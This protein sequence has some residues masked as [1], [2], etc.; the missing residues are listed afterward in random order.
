MNERAA[1]ILS[2]D[3]SGVG[4]VS[5]S[6]ALPLLTA[7]DL[8][9]CALPTA[10]LSSHTGG[11][12]ANTALDL[13]AEMPKVLTHWQTLG[14]DWQAVVLGYLGRSAMAVWQAWLPQ[15]GSVPLRL[16]DPVMGDHGKLYRG[17]GAAEVVGMRRLVT[18]ATLITPNVT[19]AQA[20]LGQPLTAAAQTPAAAAALAQAVATRFG[21]DVVLTGVSLVDGAIGVFGQTA[22][23]AWAQRAP[24]T[25]GDY[26]GTGDLFTALLAGAIVRGW[27]I[28]DA[29]ALAAEFIRRA[30]AYTR[31]VTADPRFGVAYAPILP[32]LITQ[33][34]TTKEA[35]HDN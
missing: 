27:A 18:Q 20:L 13:S 9:P 23:G 2:E 8:M 26:F 11:L 17:F 21:V 24:R 14:L 19:E 12:G 22:T 4:G 16:I 29:A 5:M 25:P 6:A 1:V 33:L 3:L 34:A 7:M 30:L 35:Q 32:W 31:T 15:L 10:L 28:S